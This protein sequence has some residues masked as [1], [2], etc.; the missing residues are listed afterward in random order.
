METVFI[1]PN[2]GCELKAEYK[3][4]QYEFKILGYDNVGGYAPL[5]V[6]DKTNGERYYS[7]GY[8]EIND[9]V[10]I[11]KWK[12]G[13]KEHLSRSGKQTGFFGNKD[14]GRKMG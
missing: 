8:L 9:Q 4:I 10:I 12:N 5:L 11:S 1:A 6:V 3:G 2:A 7:N 13:K 14:T